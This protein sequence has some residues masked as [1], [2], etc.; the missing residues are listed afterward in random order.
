MFCVT[1]SMNPLPVVLFVYGGAWGSGDKS[2]YSSFCYQVSSQGFVVMAPNYTYFP[3]TE[4]DGMIDQIK[5][6]ILWCHRNS[7][8]VD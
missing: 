7:K 4:I 5:E 3:E 2:M 6:S 8:C 1:Q